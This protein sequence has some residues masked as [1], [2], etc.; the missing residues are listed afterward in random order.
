[1]NSRIDLIVCVTARSETN[2]VLK[3][4][5]FDIVNFDIVLHSLEQR[6]VRLVMTIWNYVGNRRN[7]LMVEAKILKD[8]EGLILT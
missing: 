1:M 3:K 7:K 4:R 8:V 6:R 5:N 2:P